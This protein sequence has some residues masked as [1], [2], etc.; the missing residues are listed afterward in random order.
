MSYVDKWT[1]VVCSISI[2]MIYYAPWGFGVFPV[3]YRLRRDAHLCRFISGQVVAVAKQKGNYK[4]LF[5]SDFWEVFW[6]RV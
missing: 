2:F 1:G 6:R 4:Y 5:Y 3:D